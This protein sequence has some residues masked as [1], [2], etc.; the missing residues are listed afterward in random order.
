MVGILPRLDPSN[1][2]T[3][4]RRPLARKGARCTESPDAERAAANHLI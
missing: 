2:Q 4:A 1:A 3:K